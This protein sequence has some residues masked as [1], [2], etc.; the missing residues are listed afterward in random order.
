MGMALWAGHTDTV[1]ILQRDYNC[2]LNEEGS[3]PVFAPFREKNYFT[4]LT[5]AEAGAPDKAK[6]LLKPLD[7]L[8]A[9]SIRK[10]RFEHF[11]HAFSVAGMS[12]ILT[13]SNLV[14]N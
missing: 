1:A 11:F 14:G 7:L 9:V 13:C 12:L 10:V 2:C 4:P 8:R 6:A 5:V 3:T